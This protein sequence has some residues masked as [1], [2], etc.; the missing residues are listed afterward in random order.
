MA[1]KRYLLFTIMLLVPFIVSAEND[2]M[3]LV[4]ENVKYYRTITVLNNSEVMRNS[5]LGEVTSFTTE[6]TEEEYNSVDVDSYNNSNN[7]RG[8]T[9][10]TIETTYKKLH[11]TIFTHLGWYR[12]KATLDWKLIPSTRSYD[13]IGIGHY[14]TVKISGEVDFLQSYCR[15]NRASDC[16]ED[17]TYYSKSGRNG[18]GAMFKIPSGTLTSVS[19]VIEFDVEKNVTGTLTEQLAVGDYS[20]ATS[21]INIFDAENFSVDCSGIILDSAIRNYYDTIPSADADWSGSW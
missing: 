12:Y 4:A 3:E 16:Y 10:E 19:Q 11:T 18:S 13:I 9:T 14:A 6:V 8:L 1:V 7:S 15:S 5:N 17:A 20:H 2:E 21:S